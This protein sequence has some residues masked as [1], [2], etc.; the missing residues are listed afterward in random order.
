MKKLGKK[1]LTLHLQRAARGRFRPGS[2]DWRLALK[3]GGTRPRVHLRRQRGAHR[4]PVAAAAAGRARHRLQGP[5][6]A[7]EL[8]RGHLRQ[9]GERSGMSAHEARLQ[10]P[11]VLA[12]YR[13]EMARFRRTLWQSLVT[14]VI[15]TSLYFVVF[16]AAIGSR[17]SEVDGVPYG[18]FIVPGLIMLSL[19]TESLNN[20]SFGI[21]LPKFT[22]TIYE[23]LSAPVSPLRDRA[24]LRRRGGDQVGDP[25]AGDPRHGE[26][27]RA[28]PHRASGLDDRLPACSPRR[29]SACSASSSASGRS[30]FEQLQFIPMLVITPLTFLGG[31]FYSIDMLPPAWRTFSLFNPVVYLISGF[32]WSF[33]GTSDVDV[34]VS[35]ATTSVSSPSASRSSPGSSGPATGSRPDVVRLGCRKHDS[36]T[37]LGKPRPRKWPL[38]ISTAAFC[39]DADPQLQGE[40]KYG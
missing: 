2:R 12:I 11:C 40:R 26:P 13:F 5:A 21:Y 31:A 22:G 8:A 4:H 24:R 34:G 6:D 1:Q 27:L 3:D 18:A 19:F 17:M 38:E 33:Y 28:D 29:P 36:P 20:A 39:A 23:L 14:P 37:V 15:T 30:G 16:G 25:R 10:P 32:R 9:P 35:A 7:P